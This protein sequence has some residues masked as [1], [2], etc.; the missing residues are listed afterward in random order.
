M[1]RA[2]YLFNP[3]CKNISEKVGGAQK[4][5]YLLSTELAKD[6]NIDVHFIVADFGQNK[7]EIIEGVTLWRS[8]SFA[9]N[10]INR[11]YLF[12]KCLVN[13]NADVFIFRSADTGVALAVLFIKYILKKKTVYMLASNLEISTK[14]SRKYF[15]CATSFLMNLVYKKANNIIVQ[16]KEAKMLF[17][18]NYRRMP[19][20]VLHNVIP[21]Q[22]TDFNANRKYILWVGRLDAI[23]KPELFLNLAK[24]FPD[25]QFI[26][27]APIVIE[28]RKYGLKFQKEILKQ[29]N[30]KY[31][32]FVKP[33]KINTFYKNAK[34]YIITSESEGFS[35]TM[36]EAMAAK[37]PILSY[38]VNPDNIIN[39]YKLG[40]C[41]DGDM[42]KM[43]EFFDE[44]RN[45]TEL[46]ND[47]G[48][49][50]IKY[51]IQNHSL[52]EEALKLKQLF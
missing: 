51:L 40:Y 21:I 18:E 8:F 4:Q 41:A 38:K 50:S 5:A 1:P 9:K 12:F 20:I 32:D 17:S 34:V 25:E 10:I 14:E 22:N 24:L 28:H 52:E 48:D 11:I 47:L 37:C 3:K 35:N 7:K 30:I 44:M 15:G 29:K 16:T 26:M 49:N 33:D 19:D 46:L 2:Y 43:N 27:I 13:V 31:Y 39:E 23:K 42:G 36:M 45:N 6:E